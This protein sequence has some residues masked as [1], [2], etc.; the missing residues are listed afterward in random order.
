M[1]STVSKFAEADAYIR[2]VMQ[3]AQ[4]AK[5][6][7]LDRRG[8]LKLAG[9]GLVLGFYLPGSARADAETPQ[10]AGTAS[11][12]PVINAFVRVD[13]DNTI[14]VYSKAPEIGQGIK[15]ALGLIIAEEMDA[16]WSRTVVEQAP[17]DGKVYG[18]QGAG[19]STTIPRAWDQLR[20]AGAAAKAMLIAAAA[21]QWGVNPAEITAR[22]SVLTHTASGKSATYGALA[23]A[24]AKLPTPDPATLKLKT[25][26]QYRLLGQRFRGVDDHKLV[27]GQPLFGIDVRLPGMVYAAYAKCP[28]TG[29]KVKSANVDE[30]KAQ[31]NVLDAFI[32]E[33]NGKPTELMPG[34]AIIARNTWAAFEARDKLDVIWDESGAAK[35]SSRELAARAKQHAAG[36]F[37]AKADSN[38]G[39]VDRA[40][41]SAAKTIEAY[42]EYPFVAHANMEPQNTTAWW[43]DG[44]MELWAPTQQPNRGQT[45]VAG[46]LGLPENKVVVHQTRVGNGFGRRLM[47]DYMCEAAVIARRVKGPV[48]LQ[49]SR[50]DDFAHDFLRPAGYHQ[51]KGA[52]DKKGRLDAWQEHFI[53]FT[54]DGQNPSASAGYSRFIAYACKAPNLRR[55]QTLVNL[56][57]PTGPWRAPG[58]NAQYFAQQCFMHELALAAGRDHVEFLLD[59]VRRE[60]PELAPPKDSNFDPARAAGVIKLCAEKAGWGKTLP[61]GRGLGLAWCYAHAGHV[62]Q[63]VELSV[64]ANKR[65][66]IHRVV[67]AADVGQVVERAGAESQAQGAC[68][69]AFSMALAQQINIEN[70]RVREQNFGAYPILRMPFAPAIVEVYFV[71]SN[72]PPTGMGE[73]ALPAMAP[74]VANAIFAAT[75]ERVRAMPFSRLGYR[76]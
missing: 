31:P 52:V 4:S 1:S 53:T 74:A 71:E 7:P 50:A 48:K 54:A 34:I 42:Y 19:G 3:A 65:I 63:A 35:E 73:P 64:D 26:E 39:D 76:V 72:F 27:T 16:D 41:A 59:A 66:T 62:A 20:Q 28:S 60:V 32:I 33:G 9:A 12:A 2:E 68:V 30:I 44:V 17:I 8:F 58:C 29:G 5:A 6:L 24:A 38:I 67:V 75:G 70:G 40:F 69:D 13:P 55:G 43:H 25:R 21:Q 57:V 56:Q 49:W 46:V 45:L 47:N 14:T 61:K 36:P 37:P 15:T 10:A 22:D 51:L 23:T 18:Y 11:Q